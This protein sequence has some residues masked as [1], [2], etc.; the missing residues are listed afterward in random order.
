MIA[1]SLLLP[2][3]VISV[4]AHRTTTIPVVAETVYGVFANEC[5]EV[6]ISNLTIDPDGPF[7]PGD[8]LQLSVTGFN[9]PEGD[10]VQF[11]SWK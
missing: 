9:L 8:I 6:S 5:G 4:W 2:I 3:G 1:L 7:C 11:L 10:F